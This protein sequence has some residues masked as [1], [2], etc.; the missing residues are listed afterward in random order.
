MEE[1]QFGSLS[2]GFLNRTGVDMIVRTDLEYTGLSEAS[3][4]TAFPEDPSKFG[5]TALEVNPNVWLRIQRK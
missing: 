1:F 5:F 2:E 3:D 4:F